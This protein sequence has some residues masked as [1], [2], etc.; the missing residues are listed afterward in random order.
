[1]IS[2]SSG[3]RPLII[4]RRAA[5]YV[6]AL[7]T[8]QIFVICIWAVRYFVIHDKSSPMLGL[9][10]SVYWAA[11]RVAIEHGA[12]AIYSPEYMR[13]VE[14]AVRPFMDYTPWP[15]PPTF[16]LAVIPLGILPFGAALT[17]FLLVSVIAYA[18]SIYWVVRRF[19][20]QAFLYVLAFP[21]VFLVVYCGQNSFITTAI[22]AAA[23]VAIPKRP[24]LAGALIA[25]LGIKPQLG[26]LF[27]LALI[28]GCQWRALASAAMFSLLFW[29]V[30]FVAFG[31]DAFITFAHALPTFRRDWVDNAES[32]WAGLPSIYGIARVMGAGSAAAYIV[33]TILVLPVVAAAA[34]LW[35]GNARYELRAAALALATLTV[36]PYVLYYDLVWMAL[37]IAF[38]AIDMGKYGATRTEVAMLVFAWLIPAQAFAALMFPDIF[39]WTPAV[40]IALLAIISLRH[41]RA[42]CQTQELAVSSFRQQG[43]G[44]YSR[45]PPEGSNET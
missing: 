10:F 12:V 9:D 39:Q 25:M 13:P 3:A 27:P 31:A 41:L 24:L 22:A 23:L 38:L 6:A 14:M 43:V 34:W 29:G 16:L 15:Y 40:L 1:M 20:S 35:C 21:A 33:H 42:T 32:I 30:S 44:E 17:L 7:L 37:P 4:P 11:A 2:S 19:G 8:V 26:V 45:M 5:V 18:V 36:Q 28:C